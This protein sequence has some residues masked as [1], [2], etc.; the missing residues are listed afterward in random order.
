M[1]WYKFL[2]IKLSTIVKG[3]W[4]WHGNKRQHLKKKKMK[5]NNLVIIFI[6]MFQLSRYESELL[7][8]YLPSK[9]NIK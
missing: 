2:K 8:Y 1:T 3:Y 6:F 7:S 9:I 4:L 5:Y